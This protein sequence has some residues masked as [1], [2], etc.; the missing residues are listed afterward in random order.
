MLIEED[1]E[2]GRKRKREGRRKAKSE[3]R[4]RKDPLS[5]SQPT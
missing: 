1:K 2:E 3:R 4:R 5:F